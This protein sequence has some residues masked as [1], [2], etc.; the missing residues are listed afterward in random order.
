MSNPSQEN[1]PI[2]K[3]INLLKQVLPMSGDKTVGETVVHLDQEL[4]RPD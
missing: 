1:H 2:E 3:T 4:A